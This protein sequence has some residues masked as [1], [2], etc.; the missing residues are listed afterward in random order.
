M[1]A[2]ARSNIDG[3]S[4]RHVNRLVARTS[5]PSVQ[6]LDAVLKAAS[7]WIT[8]QHCLGTGT[9]HDALAGIA[10]FLA[11]PLDASSNPTQ[12]SRSEGSS[13][14]TTPTGTVAMR[15]GG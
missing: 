6:T 4:R 7:A 8:D 9:D 12:Q 3:V 13:T 14:G 2:S 10:A 1:P 5:T 11:Q 15:T